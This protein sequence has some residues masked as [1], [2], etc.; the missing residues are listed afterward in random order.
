MS[1]VLCGLHEVVALL[2]EAETWNCSI[3]GFG[4][5]QTAAL[6]RAC[7]EGPTSD[8]LFDTGIAMISGFLCQR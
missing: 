2:S 1:S 6:P 5:S 8:C 3:W 4:A 7:M